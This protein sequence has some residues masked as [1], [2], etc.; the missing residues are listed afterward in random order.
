M[1]RLIATDL[2][3]CLMDSRGELPP[4]FDEAFRK[5]QEKGVTFAAASGRS[6]DGVQR[7]FARYAEQMALISDNGARVYH[8]GRFLLNRTLPFSVYRPVTE[9]MRKLPALLPVVCTVNGAYVEDLRYIRGDMT[10]L[11]NIYYPNCRECIFD[12]IP[13]EIIKYALLYMGD[14]EKDIYPH[15]RVYDNEKIC[16]QVTAYNWIDVYEKAVSKGTGVA[17]LQE[18]LG[19][20]PEETMI[21]GD[22]LNDLAM[23]DHA[24]ISCAPAN[25]HPAVRE[26]FTKTVP[27]NAEYGVP[28]TILELLA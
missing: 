14:I 2:D 28:R 15:L 1:I 5:M 11:M 27:S 21:F 22:Y 16:V 26:R 8:K 12:D 3:G 24:A 19:I 6:F 20:H 10:E 23:A 9:A 17:F 13:E 4:N 18:K 25:A 7:P